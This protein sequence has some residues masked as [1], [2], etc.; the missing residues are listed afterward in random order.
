MDNLF[1]IPSTALTADNTIWWVKDGA[2]QRHV[3]RALFS[4]GTGGRLF[5]PQDELPSTIQVVRQP[6]KG[7]L[8]DMQVQAKEDGA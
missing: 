2:L 1:A 5:I 3:T 4:N 7:Y 8:P 6:M